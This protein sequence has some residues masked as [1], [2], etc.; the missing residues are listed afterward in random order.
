MFD[1]SG[2]LSDEPLLEVVD[3]LF[4]RVVRPDSVGLPHSVQMFVSHDLDE[5]VIPATEIHTRS[6]DIN[7]FHH[8]ACLTVKSSGAVDRSSGQ[9]FS[10]DE[11]LLE[12]NGASGI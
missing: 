3:C 2:I 6:V 9:F 12:R 7:D 1:P 8:I 10:F 11:R 4:D 5:H